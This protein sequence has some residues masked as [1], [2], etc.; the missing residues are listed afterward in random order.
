MKIN[1]CCL[2]SNKPQKTM[3]SQKLNKTPEAVIPR[4]RQPIISN[5]AKLKATIC[6]DRSRNKLGFIMLDKICRN[7]NSD[8]MIVQHNN[9]IPRIYNKLIVFL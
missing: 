9:K 8:T 3:R 6:T 7:S 4:F 2:N 5:T 1:S